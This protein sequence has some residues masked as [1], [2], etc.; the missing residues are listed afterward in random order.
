MTE[1]GLAAA[2]DAEAAFYIIIQQLNC[3]RR[4][5]MC[6]MRLMARSPEAVQAIQV[7]SFYFFSKYRLQQ[8]RQQRDLR[9]YVAFDISQYKTSRIKSMGMSHKVYIGAGVIKHHWELSDLLG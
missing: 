6:C 7:P 4:N 1:I 5:E 3:V 8:Q 2:I 9:L